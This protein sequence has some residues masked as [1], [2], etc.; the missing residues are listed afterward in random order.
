MSRIHS[1]VRRAAC[2]ALGVAAIAMVQSGPVAAAGAAK[3]SEAGAAAEVAQ[4]QA[5]PTRVAVLIDTSKAMEPHMADLRRALPRFFSALE[6]DYQITLFEFGDRPTRLVDY[7]TDRSTLAAAAG[8][9]FARSNA[10]AYALEAIMEASRDLRIRSSERPVIVVIT[11]QGP[12]FSERYHKTVLDDLQAAKA[13]LHSL[14]L[15]RRRVPV[16]ND[17]IREREI[18]LS[19]GAELTGGRRDDLLTSMALGDRLS[20]LARELT[21]RNRRTEP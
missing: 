8:R 17:G 2:L 5:G 19:R 12:E 15:T 16:F 3:A 1:F 18:A 7:T 14:V 20:D 10:G 13:T 6:G 21:D 11:A 4:A 9:L